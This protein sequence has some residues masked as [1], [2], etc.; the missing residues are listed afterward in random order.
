MFRERSFLVLAVMLFPISSAYAFKPGHVSGHA[1]ATEDGVNDFSIASPLGGS[2][3]PYTFSDRAVT[4]IVEANKAVDEVWDL[5]A[6]FWI[7]INHCDAELIH[8]CKDRVNQLR[9][10]AIEQLLAT[11]DGGPARENDCLHRLAT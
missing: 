2:A 10:A 5:G 6:G 3:D 9:D 8:E 4:E 11:K 7:P 1:G